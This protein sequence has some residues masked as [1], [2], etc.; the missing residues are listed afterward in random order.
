MKRSYIKSIIL[1]FLFLSIGAYAQDFST[2]VTDFTAVLQKSKLS[3][4]DYNQFIEL[5]D[6]H[7]IPAHYRANV[8]KKDANRDKNNKIML[9]MESD[10]SFIFTGSNGKE[11]FISFLQEIKNL[12]PSE[13]YFEK[14]Y[15]SAGSV[16][17]MNYYMLS[18]GI[19]NIQMD[20]TSPPGFKGIVRKLINK[21]TPDLEQEAGEFAYI[22]RFSNINGIYKMVDA[23]SYSDKRICASC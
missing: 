10:S 6:S 18:S 16:F 9:K 4:K 14:S 22:Y 23:N 8:A 1:P 12:P 21:G 15:T 7:F 20:I 19:I 11:A 13:K 3:Q 2:F 17:V 5:K